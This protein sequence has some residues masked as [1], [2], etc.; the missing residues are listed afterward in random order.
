M[1]IL[2][3]CSCGALDAQLVEKYDKAMELLE[4][5]YNNIFA[6]EFKDIE[7]AFLDKRESF[8]IR[9]QFDEEFSGKIIAA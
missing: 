4:D 3:T 7:E 5:T 8:Y 6:E 1:Y 2:A 9:N